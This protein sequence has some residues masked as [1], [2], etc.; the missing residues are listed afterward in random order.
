MSEGDA[1][2]SVRSE[3][4]HLSTSV[5]CRGPQ[6]ALGEPFSYGSA[7]A[8]LAAI[9]PGQQ[10]AAGTEPA[11]LPAAKPTITDASTS[12]L[13]TGHSAS[14]ERQLVS[15]PPSAGSSTDEEHFA[16]G[17]QLSIERRLRSLPPGPAL[18]DSLQRV[19]AASTGSGELAASF[20]LVSGMH[21]PWVLAPVT[22]CSACQRCEPCCLLA[23]VQ[24]SQSAAPAERE[25]EQDPAEADPRRAGEGPVHSLAPSRRPLLLP[26]DRG[27][28]AL[29]RGTGL[30]RC[31]ASAR[32]QAAN[33][34]CAARQALRLG[35]SG[36]FGLWKASGPCT[37]L[38]QA[39]SGPVSAALRA[40]PAVHL[41]E[42]LLA[43]H[44][45]EGY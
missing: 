6:E 36:N 44:L 3:S 32:W 11:A 34:E 33:R 41:K 18:E 17:L 42:R 38:R 25:A 45:K 8:E 28:A 16:T 4:S 1:W 19:A 22:G 35:A 39:C 21:A 20:Q 31:S 40:L 14:L 5:L 24:S 10:P 26:A 27:L 30:C 2:P 37:A 13:L 15:V 7:W 43:K 12:P 23:G 9:D 29:D